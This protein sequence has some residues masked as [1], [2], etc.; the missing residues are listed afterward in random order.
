MSQQTDTC[1][2][3]VRLQRKKRHY[4]PQKKCEIKTGNL[5]ATI[6]IVTQN[7]KVWKLIP[8]V[9]ELPSFFIKRRVKILEKH[10]I[11]QR[12]ETIWGGNGFRAQEI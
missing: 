8:S 7:V 11:I 4:S 6:A 12:I 10:F 1:T 3:N 9:Y 5:Q 2:Q